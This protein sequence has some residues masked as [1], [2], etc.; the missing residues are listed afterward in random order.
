MK[1]LAKNNK[2]APVST[3]L[4]CA[5]SKRKHESKVCFT[6]CRSSESSVEGCCSEQSL[7]SGG[8]GRDLED[9]KPV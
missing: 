5:P 6:A 4:L 7:Q 3:V 9:G 1:D 2:S 8:D